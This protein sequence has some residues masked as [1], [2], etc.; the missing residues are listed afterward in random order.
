MLYPGQIINGVYEVIRPIGEGGAGLVYLA[1]HLN[2]RKQVVVKRLKSP[3][4]DISFMR[5]EADIL[6]SLH[7][8]NLP[9]VYDFVSMENEVYTII[10]YIDG[11]TMAEY[12]DRQVRFEEEQLVRWLKQLLEALAYLHTRKPA[13]IHSDV[14]PANIMIDRHGDICLIDFNVSSGGGAAAEI[15]GYSPRYASP[16]QVMLADAVRSGRGVDSVRIDTRTDIYSL[17]A[18][19]FEFMSGENPKE[20]LEGKKKPFENPVPYSEGLQRVIAGALERNVTQRYQSAQEMLAD[21]SGMTGSARE[22]SS[23]GKKQIVFT[24]VTLFTFAAGLVMAAAGRWGMLDNRIG[25]RVAGLKT[26]YDQGLYSQ[27]EDG[28]RELLDDAVYALFLRGDSGRK[29]EILSLMGRAETRQ[30]EVLTVPDYTDARKYLGEAWKLNNTDWES[31]IAYAEVLG[32]SDYVNDA[33]DVCRSIADRCPDEVMLRKTG[34]AWADI[35]MKYEKYPEAL[36]ALDRISAE[37]S[38]DSSFSLLKKRADIYYQAAESNIMIDSDSV[39]DAKR[40]YEELVEVSGETDDWLHYGEVI[41]ILDTMEEDR[42]GE[43]VMILRRSG[44]HDFRIYMRLS[45]YELLRLDNGVEE[46]S[47]TN[48]DG[49]YEEAE[50][51]YASADESLRALYAEEMNYLRAKIAKER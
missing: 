27:T 28:G 26:D 47:Y 46:A 39:E 40:T 42:A 41:R 43:A 7:H 12:I 31:G 8:S 49:W 21:L 44:R 32:A 24:A 34:I 29:A 33:D 20:L 22:A 45:R 2:L 13:I 25:E 5:Q 3:Y 30:Q 4:M 18:S 1:N 50:N 14:K 51:L 37:V 19:F 38:D 11:N 15:S 6:K 48:A 9:Q 23:L 10:D 16:E 17:G 36:G 35:D